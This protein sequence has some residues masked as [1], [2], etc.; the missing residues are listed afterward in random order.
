MKK[1]FTNGYQRSFP[2]PGPFK[3]PRAGAVNVRGYNR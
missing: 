3:Q 2:R 1:T